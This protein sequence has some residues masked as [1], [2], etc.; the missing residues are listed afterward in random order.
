MPIYEYRC[1]ECGQTFDKFVRSM[2]AQFVVKCP[3]CGSQRCTKSISLFA[4]A[5][6][7]SPSSLGASCAPSG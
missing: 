3:K 6:S 4:S 7:S 2:S 5:A 1:E